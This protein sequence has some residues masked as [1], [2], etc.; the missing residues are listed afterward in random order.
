M[1]YMNKKSREDY[2]VALSVELD[3][4]GVQII[5]KDDILGD[6]GRHFEEGAAQGLTEEQICEKLGDVREIAR[7]YAGFEPIGGGETERVNSNG[8]TDVAGDNTAETEAEQSKFSWGGLVGIVCIDI[9]VFSWAIPALFSLAAGFLS[10]VFGFV[11]S[12]ITMMIPPTLT[13]QIVTSLHP[14]SV[15]FLGIALIALG[16]LGGI[17]GVYIVRGC[18]DCLK[19]VINLHG[20][21]IIGRKVFRESDIKEKDEVS[22]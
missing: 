2:V 22:T 20:E 1:V 10:L 17:L 21:W 11:V 9:F 8:F 6:F 12:G 14:V 18:V 4:L 13:G 5:E 3:N 15:V 7:Q 16:G 19:W